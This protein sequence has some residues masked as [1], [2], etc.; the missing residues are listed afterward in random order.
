MT[1]GSTK[2]RGPRSRQESL[3]VPK[4]PVDFI[5]LGPDGKPLPK[6]IVENMEKLL[7]GCVHGG[8]NHFTPGKANPK[9]DDNSK[10]LIEEM[11]AEDAVE[12]DFSMDSRDTSICNISGV[13]SFQDPTSGSSL[14]DWEGP[15]AIPLDDSIEIF[16]AD[17]VNASQIYDV[18]T[19]SSVLEV[20]GGQTNAVLPMDV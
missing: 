6:K 14:S 8:S 19:D 15:G 12:E 10:S 9:S 18:S 17:K 2:G 20:K 13:T 4:S 11:T 3:E 5:H 7:I 16:F 1:P